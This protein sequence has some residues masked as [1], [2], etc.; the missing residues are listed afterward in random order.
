MM[1]KPPNSYQVEVK[2]RSEFTDAEGQSALALLHSLGLSAARDVRTSKI[3]EIRGGV[4]SGQVQQAAR[5][6]L[7]DPVTQEFRLVAATE[8]VLNGMSHWRVEVWLKSSVTDPVGDTVRSAIAEMGLPQPE[9]VRVGTAYHI[10]GK[11]G[12][13]QLE[14]VVARGLANP[15]IHRFTVTETHP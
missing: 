10:A 15:V 7:C 4:N 1:N 14:K 6:L 13:N 8:P 2:L 12:R 11:C 9:I 3:Y 5:D